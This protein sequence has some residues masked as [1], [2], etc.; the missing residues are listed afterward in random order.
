M[1]ELACP[2]GRRGAHP[3]PPRCA[4]PLAGA[5]FPPLIKRWGGSHLL[6]A[7]HFSP[8]MGGARLLRS[9]QGRS[10]GAGTTPRA[11]FAAYLYRRA[12]HCLALRAESPRLASPT[13]GLIGAP[14]PP[15]GR[16]FPGEAL[17]H[18]LA[19]SSDANLSARWQ[20]FGFLHRWTGSSRRSS[21]RRMRQVPAG[22]VPAAGSAGNPLQGGGRE[23]GQR[24]NPV[25]ICAP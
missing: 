8:S 14:P 19:G 13:V 10:A 12:P 22:A 15:A 23:N 6:P 11:S 1:R 3:P 5:G 24:R 18:L 9:S 7:L 17:A 16:R 25:R 4:P 20:T 2:I 21:P